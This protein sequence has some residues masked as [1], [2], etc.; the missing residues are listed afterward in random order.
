MFASYGGGDAK[1]HEH[2]ELRGLNTRL[3]FWG[4]L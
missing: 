3:G 1:G 4:I 2:N